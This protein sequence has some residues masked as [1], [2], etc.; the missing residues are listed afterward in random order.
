MSKRPRIQQD[1]MNLMTTLLE[2]RGDI[3][4]PGPD[5][6]WAA[7]VEPKENSTYT[8][9]Q[10]PVFVIVHDCGWIQIRPA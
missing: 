7:Y 6:Q 9:N 10:R 8:S 1:H 4:E 5:G 2:L 3:W